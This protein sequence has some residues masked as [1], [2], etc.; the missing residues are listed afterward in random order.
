MTCLLDGKP[1]IGKLPPNARFVGME[2][3]PNQNPRYSQ[4]LHPWFNLP[5][6]ETEE[7]RND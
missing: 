1:F 2:A 3:E 4:K 6:Y 5:C 7:S